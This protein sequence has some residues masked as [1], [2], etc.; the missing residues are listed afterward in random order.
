MTAGRAARVARCAPTGLRALGVIALVWLVAAG[1]ISWQ[2]KSA[3]DAARVQAW[4]AHAPIETLPAAERV[5][6]PVALGR[7]FCRLPVAERARLLESAEFDRTV[8]AM[9]AGELGAL[10]ELAVPAG[11]C[12]LL[13]DARARSERERPAAFAASVRRARDH[14]LIEDDR[15]SAEA[16]R[17]LVE[18]GLA[19]FSALAGAEE[20]LAAVPLIDR[21]RGMLGVR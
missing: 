2:K 11:V 13:L 8:R 5:W 20:R 4:L 16:V 7:V 1:I 6:R 17:R 18:R 10:H 9:S 19:A 12:G 14:L 15:A 3:P 21:L